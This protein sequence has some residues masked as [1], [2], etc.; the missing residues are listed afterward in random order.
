METKYRV[1]L[2]IDAFVNLFLGAVLLSFPAGVLGFLGLPPTNTYFYAT[3]LG[4]VIFGIGGALC[5]E[6]W[7]A[8]RGVRG[9]GLGGAIV[10]NICGAGVLLAWLIP[11]GMDLPLRGQV[12]LWGVAVVVLGIGIAEIAAGAWKHS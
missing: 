6:L 4:G 12:L 9:L 8:T 10:I 2:T 5:M 7:G 11:G 3:I 1:L